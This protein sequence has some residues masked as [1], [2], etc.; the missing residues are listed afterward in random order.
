MC[1]KNMATPCIKAWTKKWRLAYMK[2]QIC[3]R[4]VD[5]FYA[6]STQQITHDRQHIKHNK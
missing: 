6:N 4:L 3:G 1:I 2:M 5:G